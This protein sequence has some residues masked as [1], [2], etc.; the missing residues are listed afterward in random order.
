MSAKLL[1]KVEMAEGG[2]L[3]TGVS[4]Q[5]SF[6]RRAILVCVCVCV[7]SEVKRTHTHTD[8][9]SD[10]RVHLVHMYPTHIA[11]CPAVAQILPYIKFVLQHVKC[12]VCLCERTHPL[13]SSLT[14]LCAIYVTYK[15]NIESR[16]RYIYTYRHARYMCVRPSAYATAYYV[17]LVRRSARFV[18]IIT[19]SIAA[20]VPTSSLVPCCYSCMQEE[21]SLAFILK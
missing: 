10:Q 18:V 6:H 19:V 17:R 7:G 3:L 14:L 2:Q 21:R 11:N 16:Y 1:C 9:R 13:C 8:T 4:H 15:Y 5:Q 12:M 20:T